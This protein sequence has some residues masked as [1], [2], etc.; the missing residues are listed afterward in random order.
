M[1][2]PQATPSLQGL[3][4]STLPHHLR[5]VALW[6]IITLTVGYTTGLVFV[7][8]TTRLTPR[9][10]AERYRGNQAPEGSV[11]HSSNDLSTSGDAASQA[12]SDSSGLTPIGESSSSPEP[13]MQF[14]KSFA[15]MLNITHT[16][17]LAMVTFL[18]LCAAVFA[19][20]SRPS[21]RL[22]SILIVEPFIAI[23]TTFSSL[24]LMRYVHESF[25]YL[26]V[27]SSASMAIC[28]YVMIWYS[29]MELVRGGKT[30]V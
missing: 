28:F 27:A 14:E 13:E 11:D 5:L 19:L 23:L 9:G 4:L 12:M 24:W 20:T 25:S 1:T 29:F 15:E 2:N 26:L 30:N 8:H 18:A 3:S 10:A 16:H 17:V 6:F 21:P 22:K 7:T